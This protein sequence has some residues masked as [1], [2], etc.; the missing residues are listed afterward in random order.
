[1]KLRTAVKP[2]LRMKGRM[3]LTIGLALAA[4]TYP[5]RAQDTTAA[6]PDTVGAAESTDPDGAVTTT[7]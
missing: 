1:M 2:F 6:A 7:V 5:A 3:A 4:A